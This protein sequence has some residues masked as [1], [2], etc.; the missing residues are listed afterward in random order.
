MALFPYLLPRRLTLA[1]L[2]QMEELVVLALMLM[3]L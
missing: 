3:L 1:A 2:P